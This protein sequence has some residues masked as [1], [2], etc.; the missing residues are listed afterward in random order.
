[1]IRAT[2]KQLGIAVFVVVASVSGIRADA[3]NAFLPVSA[4][5]SS[6]P[7]ASARIGAPKERLFRVARN[8]LASVRDQ[9]VGRGT[10]RLVLNVDAD[11]ELGVAIEGMSPTRWGYS[12]SGRIDDPTVGFVTL[13][14]HEEVVAGHIWTPDAAYEL[15]PIGDGI[16]AWRDLKDQPAFECG[17]M[18]SEVD[19]IDGVADDAADRSIV[20]ILVVYTPAAEE[21]VRGW[22]DST[23]AARMWIEAFND[24]AIALANDAFER[25]GAFVSLNLVGI[26]RVDYEGEE[27]WL[28]LRS[29]HVQDLRDDL[30]ADLV[31]ATVGC[32]GGAAV[33]DGLSFLTAGS[34]SIFVAHEVGHNF[35]LSHER[36]Q[37]LSGRSITYP[38]QYEHGYVALRDI[39]LGFTPYRRRCTS[40]IMAYGDLCL[41]YGENSRS[42]IEKRF[43]LD[44]VPIF[45]SPALLHPSDGAR[46][47]MSRFG[48]SMG[49]GGPADAVLHLNRAR[50]TVADFRPRRSSD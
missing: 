44:F 13:V 29:D 14:V 7:L 27:E 8:E 19:A 5:P 26:E 50:D 1:M 38:R 17:G 18:M 4:K 6:A 31:H 21:R 34:G 37:W 47:G 25:S 22:T 12:L 46:L 16:H 20:D 49:A 39:P 35:G 43:L 3:A 30:G 15:L 48:T 42:A 9:V 28:V 11:L 33:G 45:S 41:R 24:M 40:T 2:C 36:S 10:G 32:C 23:A